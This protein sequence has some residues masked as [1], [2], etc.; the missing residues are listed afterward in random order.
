[1]R[2][3][4]HAADKESGMPTRLHMADPDRLRAGIDCLHAV[5]R[6]VQA[7]AKLRAAWDEMLSD[8]TCRRSVACRSTRSASSP[9][10]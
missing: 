5:F 6:S 3:A 9:F 1:M 10:R 8:P 4:G 2:A 7:P